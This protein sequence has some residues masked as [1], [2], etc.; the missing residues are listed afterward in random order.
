MRELKR[1]IG[2]PDKPLAEVQTRFKKDMETYGANYP[3]AARGW[4]PILAYIWDTIV[5]RNKE[6]VAL[7]TNLQDLQL[8]FARRAEQGRGQ[9][10]PLAAAV[11]DAGERA[12]ATDRAA[13]EERREWGPSWPPCCTNSKTFRGPLTGK[14]RRRG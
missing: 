5:D 11:R 9:I 6:N 8:R 3:E 12:A 4:S 13:A 10:K 1:M 7:K 2:L 14:V